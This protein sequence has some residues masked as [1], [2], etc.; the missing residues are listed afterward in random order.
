MEEQIIVLKWSKYFNDG[1]LKQ[2]LYIIVQPVYFA[3]FWND[4][5]F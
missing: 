5:L 4:I 2:L 1:E 3:E